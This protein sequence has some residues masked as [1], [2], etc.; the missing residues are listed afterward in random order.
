M[1]YKETENY[2]ESYR[3]YKKLCLCKENLKKPVE[4]RKIFNFDIPELLDME[5]ARKL[6]PY[7]TDVD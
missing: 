4:E 2:P 3:K 5:K 7:K 6:L 1:F